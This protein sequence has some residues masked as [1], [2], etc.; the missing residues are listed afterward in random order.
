MRAIPTTGPTTAPAI[1]PALLF[2]F[3]GFGAGTSVVSTGPRST[4]VEVSVISAGD[5][6]GVDAIEYTLVYVPQNARHPYLVLKKELSLQALRDKDSS[7]ATRC[8]RKC[9]SGRPDPGYSRIEIP[10]YRW[11]RTELLLQ[12]RDRCKRTS[13]AVECLSRRTSRLD[14]QIYNPLECHSRS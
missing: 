3:A 10:Y 14:S 8:Y 2:F 1:N 11:S 4:D 13:H 7:S 9:S 6:E 12:C 5:E